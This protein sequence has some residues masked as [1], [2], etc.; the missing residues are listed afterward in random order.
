MQFEVLKPL[1]TDLGVHKPGDVIAAEFHNTA[2][3][4]S[5]RYIRPIGDKQRIDAL[6]ARIASLESQLRQLHGRGKGS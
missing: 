2:A 4:V 5:Q 6:E 1:S 3:L